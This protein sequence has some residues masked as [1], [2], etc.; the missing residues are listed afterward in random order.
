MTKPPC[1]MCCLLHYLHDSTK[2][3]VNRL[4]LTSPTLTTR[5]HR[6]AV[7][8]HT[9]THTHTHFRRGRTGD[10]EDAHMTLWQS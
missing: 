1:G 9:H 6:S 7:H 10:Y 2:H 8:T 3:C 5:A 4:P